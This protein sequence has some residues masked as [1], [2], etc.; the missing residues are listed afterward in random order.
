M[1]RQPRFQYPGALYHVMARGN[2]GDAVF[3]TDDDR[4]AFLHRLVTG[5]EW[6]LSAYSKGWN[7][8]RKR[9]GHVFQ[10]RY[11]AVPVNASDAD[12][13]YFKALADY[14]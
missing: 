10:G 2:G 11:N 14:V 1:A 13:H 9:R 4:K 3:V 5:M 6:Q 12:A 7:R 8:A